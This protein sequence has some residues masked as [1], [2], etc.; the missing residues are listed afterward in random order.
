MDTETNRQTQAQWETYRTL[1][2]IPE[3]TP[4]H[5]PY[6]GELRNFVTKTWN[7]LVTLLNPKAEPEIQVRRD[8]NGE[9][10]WRVYLPDSG[11]SF[12]FNTEAE[13]Y[14]WLDLRFNRRSTRSTTDRPV[15]FWRF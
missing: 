7:S 11:Q 6:F 1:E 4:D 10:W 2:L 14:E 5:N 13:V 9:L 8:R 15:N 3:T 12:Y